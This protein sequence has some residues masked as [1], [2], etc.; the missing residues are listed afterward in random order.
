MNLN[1]MVLFARVVQAGSFSGAG[2]A[3]GM[4]KSTVSRKIADLE[5]RLGSQLLQRTTRSLNLTEAG[6]IYHGHCVRVAA[7][8]EEAELAVSRTQDTPRGLL[9]I[10]T[11]LGFGFVGKVIA[12]YLRLYPEVKVEVI[13]SDKVVD[14]VEEGIDLAVRA[15]RLADSSLI[16]RELGMLTRFL[17]ASPEYLESNGTPGS[18]RELENHDCLLFGMVEEHSGWVLESG[19]K[20][21]EVRLRSRMV[22]NDFDIL[23]E[24]TLA[25]NGISS[26]PIGRCIEAVRAGRLRRVLPDW[27]SPMTPIQVVYPGTRHHSPKIQRFI[28]LLK[29]RMTPPPWE[30]GPLP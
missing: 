3:L 22:V 2:R 15:G 18:P 8:V 13:C 30:T 5:E 14:L 4:P 6:R 29:M 11:P 7:E 10:T 28:E 20:R 19:K 21:S 17:M 24:V 27:Q 25:G 26:L 9:R 12:E 23:Y 1:E 16:T